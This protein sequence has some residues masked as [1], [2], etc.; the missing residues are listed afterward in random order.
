MT[1]FFDGD[2][3]QDRAFT[4]ICWDEPITIEHIQTREI[5][6]KPALSGIFIQRFAWS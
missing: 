3:G 5:N 6:K 4:E 1:A 2:F